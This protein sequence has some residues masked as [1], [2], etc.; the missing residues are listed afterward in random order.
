MEPLHDHLEAVHRALAAGEPVAAEDRAL[1]ETVLADVR[2]ALAATPRE[3]DRRTLAERLRDA[4]ERFEAE[5]PELV[6]RVT[7]L[8]EGL[9]TPFR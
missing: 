3:E 8:I 6:R 5:H 1:L 9:E 4:V 2:Q 7:G